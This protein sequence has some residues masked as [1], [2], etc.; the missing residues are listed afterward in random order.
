MKS[1]HPYIWAQFPSEVESIWSDGVK[2]IVP[3]VFSEDTVLR[4]L[5]EDWWI[6]ILNT[7]IPNG[8]NLRVGNSYMQH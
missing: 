5:R 6:N 4:K 3:P 1:G 8:L 7:I 2:G